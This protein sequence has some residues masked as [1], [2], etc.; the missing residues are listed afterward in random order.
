[1]NSIDFDYMIYFISPNLANSKATFDC[2]LNFFS[3]FRSGLTFD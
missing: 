3:S 1:M 2:R